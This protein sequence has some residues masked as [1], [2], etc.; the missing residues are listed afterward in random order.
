[1][2]AEIPEPIEKMIS[3]LSATPAVRDYVR[4]I[5]LGAMGYAVSEACDLVLSESRK[6]GKLY[7]ANATQGLDG[8]RTGGAP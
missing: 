8:K 1:M 7:L 2:R 6:L 3:E 4:R 5:V